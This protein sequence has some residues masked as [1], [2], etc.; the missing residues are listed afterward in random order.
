MW[1]QH[2]LKTHIRPFLDPAIHLQGINLSD[3]LNWDRLYSFP[4]DTATLFF[5]LTTIVFLE[6]RI[7]GVIAFLW[8]LVTTGF[9]RV[10]MGWHYPSDVIGGFIL[11]VACV[12]LFTRIRFLGVI[13]ERGLQ[14]C[15]PHMYV[16]H[17]LFFIFLA[18]AY[19][20]FPGLQGVFHG[21]SVHLMGR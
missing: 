1:L 9:M 11:A 18:D 14:L 15:E 20:L 16:V 8:S 5:G 3:T 4:S 17:A 7:A 12:Y 13:F 2:H 10:A 19:V 6:N 21:F